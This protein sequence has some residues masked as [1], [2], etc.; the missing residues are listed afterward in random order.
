MGMVIFHLLVNLT[1]WQ[2][3]Q[4][5]F[6]WVPMGFMW[7]VG[8]ILVRFLRGR[9]KKKLWMAAK[10]LGIFL[11]FNIPNFWQNGLD[12]SRLIVGSA[13]LFSFEILLPM[14]A[15]IVA[16][17]GLDKLNHGKIYLGIFLAFLITADAL[18]VESYNLLFSLYGVLGYFMGKEFDLNSWTEKRALLIPA[19]MGAIGVFLIVQSW[20]LMESLVMGQ[21]VALF[22]LS[23]FCFN[24]NR[25]LVWLGK[26]SL[27]LYVAHIVVIKG[28]V[29]II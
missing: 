18:G 1:S 13:Q 10:L 6:Y 19:I 17:L 9:G 24:N 14:A 7:G 21:V 22:L 4:E 11:V 3:N 20:G 23:N 26:H 16:S 27:M 28:L 25:I 12:F 15:V 29:L 5:L 2:F 8:V